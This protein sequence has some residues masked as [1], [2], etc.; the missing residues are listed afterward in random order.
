MSSITSQVQEQKRKFTCYTCGQEIKLKRK[1]DNSGWFRF[2]LD[3]AT[4][5]N[6]R[7]KNQQQQEQQKPLAATTSTDLL[8]EVTTI[9]SQLLVLVSRL[10][11]IEAG[12][13]A[14]IG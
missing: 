9:K 4:E 7:T 2:N 10:D 8:K 3:G 13:Q 14:H 1:P 5:H 11:R 12:L 6:C